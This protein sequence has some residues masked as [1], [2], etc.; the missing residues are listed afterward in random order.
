[1][2]NPLSFYE[3]DILCDYNVTLV[4]MLC[5]SRLVNLPEMKGTMSEFARE[6]ERAGLIE[7]LVSD[8]FE[9]MEVAACACVCIV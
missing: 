7:E 4:V 1:M 5:Y 8:T 2:N 6:M 3:T 9:A